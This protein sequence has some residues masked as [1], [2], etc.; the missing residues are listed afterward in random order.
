MPTAPTMLQARDA[1]LAADLMRF[2]GANQKEIWH[3]FAESGFGVG[4]DD[5]EQH[6]REP[7]TEPIPSFA[8]QLED[9]ATITFVAKTKDGTVIPNARFFVGHYEARISPIADTNPATT[10]AANL[11]DTAQFV[12]ETYELVATAPGYGHLRGKLD[13]HKGET[14]VAVFEFS[15]TTRR[16]PPERR[17]PVTARA[18]LATLI[19]GT[20]ATN[21]TARRATDGN[22][23][24]DG[25]KATIDLAGTAP[26]KI[27][28]VQVSAMLARATAASRRC[29]SSRSGRATARWRTARP[30]PATRRRTRAMPTPSPALRR[31][32]SRRS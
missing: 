2:G 14:K 32:R 26:V 3:S 22:L 21:W 20:E 7:D 4:A 9:N 18:A 23:T 30:T 29:A 12:P 10:G 1:Q 8:S 25:K 17:R 13:F 16:R 11:D 5:V 27:K 28:K 6:G 15:R 19:D 31:G 24:V